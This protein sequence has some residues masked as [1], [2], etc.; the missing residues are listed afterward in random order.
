MTDA[1]TILTALLESR[2]VSFTYDGKPRTVEVHAV[3][4][5]SKGR[6]VFRGYQ[7]AGERH[8][9]ALY[10]LDKVEPDSVVLTERPSLAPREGY[11]MGD[12]QLVT[13]HLQIHT[14]K[15]A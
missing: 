10:S 11:T 2:C 5:T 14:E 13:I 8:G 7:V 3:G 12:K 1:E 4:V 9:W 15:A 6:Q